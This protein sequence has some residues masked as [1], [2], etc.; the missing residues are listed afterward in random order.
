MKAVNS[1]DHGDDQ[2]DGI[3]ELRKVLGIALL[4]M[5]LATFG[6]AGMGDYQPT[7]GPNRFG[8]DGNVPNEFPPYCHP[9][10]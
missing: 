6:C 10:P 4:L 9:S 3:M 8:C 5:I 7:G 1:N 2:G